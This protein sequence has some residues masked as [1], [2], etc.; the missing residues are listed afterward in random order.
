MGSMRRLLFLGLTLLMAG[1]ARADE[2]MWLIHRLKSIYPAMQERGLELPL[3]AL[4]A[5]D[6]CDI[7]DAVVA[8]DGGMGTG[9][10]ISERGLMITNH[11]VAY[12][13]LAE[14]STPERNILKE[15][16][17]ARSE[18]EEIPVA[19]KSVYF[20]KSVTDI[21]AEA[22]AYRDSLGNVGR[23]GIMGPRKLV[24]EME[25]R[26][27]KEGLE[28]WCASMWDGRVYLLYQYEVFRDIRLVG[29][30]P[31]RIGAFG[32][33]TDNWG[34]PQHKGDFALYRIYGNA[35]GRPADYDPSNR[36]IR[37]TKVLTIATDGVEEEDFAMVIGFPGRTRRYGSSFAV[38]ERMRKNP[39]VAQ[40]RHERMEII[41]RHMEADSL[42]RL[43]YSD[44]YFSLSNYADLTHWEGLCLGRYK[45]ADER[46]RL[47]AEIGE[48]LQADSARQARHGELLPQLARGYEARREAVD[49]RTWY[50]ESWFGPSRA[51]IAANRIAS[52]AARLE[53]DGNDTL[54]THTPAAA[55]LQRAVTHL[56]QAFDSATDRELLIG[57]LKHFV[58]E[59][60][61]TMWGDHL[62]EL[63]EQYDHQIEKLA[64]DAFDGSICRDAAHYS[65]YFARDHSVEELLSDPLVALAQSVGVVPFAQAVI[66]AE[67]AVG[68]EVDRYES[69][70]R[71]L[72]Y[73]YREAMGRAQY[74]DANSTMRL[75]YGRVSGLSPRD[76]V[77]YDHRSTAKGY[78]EKE[79]P[80]NYDFEVDERLKELIAHPQ[81]GASRDWTDGGIVPVNFLTD[82]DITGGNSGSPVLNA[83]G[84]IIGLAFDG[85]RESMASDMWYHPTLTRTVAVD[86]RYVMWLIDCYAEADYLL[87][88]IHF[89]D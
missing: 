17:W 18:E 6:K 49:V 59:V 88:E 56:K 77:L 69:D 27:R 79:N 81:K 37:P 25:R 51:L 29:A 87:Q 8:I 20:L 13:D 84:E 16:F 11:H 19:G 71:K 89:A 46:R 52:L 65:D 21:T 28:P 58:R 12:G 10:M 31:Q 74:P 5:A 30:P 61:R 76:G 63:W 15:G 72:Q 43:A 83:R 36:P 54:Y 44:A 38:E 1:S 42:V 57:G 80:S 2:G 68:I 60:P 14:L 40:C 73:D 86:I 50:Q 70:F 62:N 26:H 78:L 45:V 82:N 4:H 22:V 34:W 48:W 55:G 64:G 66:D 24:S 47:E 35:E 3:E 23:W 41:R 7:S 9:S 39:V 75:T 33:E 32:G 53:R 67:D 85:N